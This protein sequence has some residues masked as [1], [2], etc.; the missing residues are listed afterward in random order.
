MFGP[1]TPT[2][3]LSGGGGGGGGGSPA[4]WLPH[5]WAS[6][7]P[8]GVGAAAFDLDLMVDASAID[9]GQALASTGLAAEGRVMRL[10]PAHN[11]AAPSGRILAIVDDAPGLLAVVRLVPRYS[12]TT[13]AN[14]TGAD[15]FFG[16]SVHLDEATLG[17]VWAGG[18]VERGA[19]QTAASQRLSVWRGTGRA[20]LTLVHSAPSAAPGAHPFDIAL[21]RDGSNVIAYYGLDGAWTRIGVYAVG[22]PGVDRFAVVASVRNAANQAGAVSMDVVA[23]ATGADFAGLPQVPVA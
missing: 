15:H 22:A 1:A 21:I 23:F 18:Y 4:G 6:L 10:T 12:G 11:A 5:D 20:S 14:G 7:A 9:A 17:G 2:L 16:L 19:S 3:P 13:D 8:I